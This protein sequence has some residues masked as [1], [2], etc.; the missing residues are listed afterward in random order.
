MLAIGARDRTRTGMESPPRD[1]K[2]L[3]STIPP[4]GRKRKDTTNVRLSQILIGRAYY[5]GLFFSRIGRYELP[6]PVLGCSLLASKADSYHHALLAI[7]YQ[8]SA[9]TGVSFDRT[10]PPCEARTHDP[11]IKSQVL[12]H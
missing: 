12:Y 7:K 8:K 3:A 10:G 6:D 11:L 4:L 9:L 1:F 5:G 2:S